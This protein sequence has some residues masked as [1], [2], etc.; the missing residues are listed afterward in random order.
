MDVLL[1]LTET[2]SERIGNHSLCRPNF[3]EDKDG[4]ELSVTGMFHP[5]LQQ[6]L[7]GDFVQ[8]DI[9]MSSSSSSVCQ[10]DERM[11]EG[12]AS[13]APFVLLSGMNVFL[14]VFS[15]WNGIY[16]HTNVLLVPRCII[17][18]KV[19]VLCL[20]NPLSSFTVLCYNAY[21]PLSLLLPHCPLYLSHTHLSSISVLSLQ[22]PNMGGKSTLLRQLGVL[23]ILAH[24]CPSITCR[25]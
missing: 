9:S 4:C 15:S 11:G 12:T 21:L 16:F 10:T 13:F 14:F 1:S 24:V 22:G 25:F 19:S 20:V 18:I 5:C 3:I 17:F 7:G 8:N 6:M 2:S 23:T